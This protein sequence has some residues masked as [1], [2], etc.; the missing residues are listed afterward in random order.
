MVQNK[1]QVNGKTLAI[2]MNG[3]GEKAIFF[4]HGGSMSSKTWLAQLSDHELSAN[5]QL[6]AIDL[7]GHGNSQWFHEPDEYT[8]KKLG[9]LIRQLIELVK[10]GEFILAGLSYGTNVIGEILPPLNN[11]KGLVLTSPCIINNQLPPEVVIT[12][13]PFGHLIIAANPPEN[14]LRD[15]I[16]YATSNK[17]VAERTYKSYRNTDPA[18]RQAIGNV[19]ASAGWSDELNNIENWN[20]P[21]CVV[22]GTDEKL[23]KTNYLDTFSPLWNGKVYRIVHSAHIINEENPAVFNQ[24]LIDFAAAVF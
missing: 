8:L 12:P 1:V 15:Y 17:D 11:C 18:F 9:N 16:N 24:L 6:I 22:F 4:I 2:R 20:V 7:P 5:Y 14:E 10:P 3:T 19:T 21:V 13:G 23:V